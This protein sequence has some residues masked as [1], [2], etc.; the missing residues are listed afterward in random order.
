MGEL[1]ELRLRLDRRGHLLKVREEQ[2]NRKLELEKRVFGLNYT[3][4]QELADVE[5]LEKPG[6]SAFLYRLMGR[7]E[8]KLEQ[9]RQEA[10]AVQVKLES[11][12]RELA[13][14]TAELDETDTAL[15][16]LAG[17]EAEYELA[18]QRKAE[19]VRAAGTPEAEKLL[20][21]ETEL[22]DREQ[23]L[24]ELREALSAARSAKAR[25]KQVELSLDSAA[26]YSDWD[27]FG[28]GLM[29]DLSKH[30]AL[31][32]AQ[33]E[34]EQLQQCLQKL[35]TELVDVQIEW[36]ADVN[37]GEFE[38]FADWFFDG[39]FADWSIRSKIGNSQEQVRRVQYQIDEVLRRLEELHTREERDH[40]ALQKRMEELIVEAKL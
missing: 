25:A 37:L 29:A 13:A 6:L 28:G 32:D 16:E 33:E 9:E 3:L 23:R 12:K 31:D 36:K 27:V 30:S 18:Y 8:E 24:E 22:A 14:L 19:A 4:E 17:C 5:R 26:R 15:A 39:F 7:Q 1:K 2:R 35:R 21:W 20:G 40:D 34:A 10:Y 38:R 11:A